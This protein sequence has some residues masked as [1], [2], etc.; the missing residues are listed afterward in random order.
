MI[1]FLAGFCILALGFAAVPYLLACSTEAMVN[2]M[3]DNDRKR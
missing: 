2:R 3:R 1:H